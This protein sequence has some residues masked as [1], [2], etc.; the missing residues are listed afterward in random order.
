MRR[1]S[2]NVPG[3]GRYLLREV[4]TLQ[5]AHDA[6]QERSCTE[7]LDD[8]VDLVV[9]DKALTGYLRVYVDTA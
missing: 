9:H 8:R 3:R 5:E 4:S 6:S 7:T 2:C 1:V